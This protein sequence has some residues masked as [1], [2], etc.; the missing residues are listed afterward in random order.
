MAG[1]DP[2]YR[3]GVYVTTLLLFNG[4]TIKLFISKNFGNW[5]T[6]ALRP[7][8]IISV[9]DNQIDYYNDKV[10]FVK[11]GDHLDIPSVEDISTALQSVIS[12]LK[13]IYTRP[14]RKSVTFNH[15]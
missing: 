4:E 7:R 2:N 11:P 5:P 9:K 14:R 10:I 1:S 3:C 13:D 12:K 8:E 15:Q 6:K